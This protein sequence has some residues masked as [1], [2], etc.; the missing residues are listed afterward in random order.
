MIA[1]LVCR[2]RGRAAKLSASAFARNVAT[3]G[4]GVAAAQAI[5]VAFTPLLTRLYDPEAFGILAAYT[6]ILSIMAPM[7]TLGYAN[8]IVIPETEDG[9]RATIRVSILCGLIVAPLALLLIHIL[10]PS[11]AEWT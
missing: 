3:V 8:G 9:A 1:A 2:I 4:G 6:A 11:F 7:A 5:S 10:K